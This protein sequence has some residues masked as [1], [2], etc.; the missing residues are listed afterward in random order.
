MSLW[1]G[2]RTGMGVSLRSHLEESTVVTLLIGCWLHLQ[3]KRECCERRGHG[4]YPTLSDSTDNF[5][6]LSFTSFSPLS[7]FSLILIWKWNSRKLSTARIPRN[8]NEEERRRRRKRKRTIEREATVRNTNERNESYGWR[9][10][11]T[12]LWDISPSGLCL[13]FNPWSWGRSYER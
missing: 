5:L 6:P 8:G 7:S 13:A 12:L 4:S 10:H 3:M 11:R 2:E 9:W 1:P